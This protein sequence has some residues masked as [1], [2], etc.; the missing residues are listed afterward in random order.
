VTS[1]N[2]S[3]PKSQFGPAAAG[4]SSGKG[5]DACTGLGSLHGGALAPLL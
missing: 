1:G 5:W 3:V 2:N 4:Y